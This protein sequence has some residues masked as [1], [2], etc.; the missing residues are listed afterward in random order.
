GTVTRTQAMEGRGLHHIQLAAGTWKPATVAHEVAHAWS[1]RG[2]SALVEG[3]TTLLEAC[4]SRRDPARFPADPPR[5]DGLATLVDLREWTNGD[6][7]RVSRSAGYT[8]SER[9]FA[10]LAEVVPERDLW[11]S[12]WTWESF[13]AVLAEAGRTGDLLRSSLAGGVV[14]QRVILRDIDE[15]GILGL[16]ERLDG[17]DPGAWDT[18]GDGWWDGAPEDVRARGVRLPSGYAAVCAGWAAGPL[19]ATI[20]ARGG[21]GR[22]EDG[23]PA[24]LL[25]GARAKDQTMPITVPPGASIGLSMRQEGEGWG[26]VDG[27]GLQKDRRCWTNHGW[28]VFVASGHEAALAP[29]VAA[30]QRADTRVAAEVGAPKSHGYAWAWEKKTQTPT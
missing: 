5:T 25:D 19:G 12:E 13:D 3:A 16:R 10:M 7:D 11:R 20:V 2:P 21:R 9:M 1:Y 29:F 17:T 23:V 28:T 27:V 4:I 15:D 30:L 18:D 24:V 14:T 22:R 8:A 6:A 26:L